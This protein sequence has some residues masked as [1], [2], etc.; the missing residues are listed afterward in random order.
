MGKTSSIKRLPPELRDAID[1]ALQRHVSYDEIVG[2]VNDLGGNVSRSAIGRYAKNYR[3]LVEQMRQMSGLLPMVSDVSAEQEVEESRLLS[4]L[5]RT[6]AT[7]TLVEAAAD[8]GAVDGK[9]FNYK[10]SG[11]EKAAKV[12]ASMFD[13]RKRLEDMKQRCAAAAE[14]AGQRAGASPETIA[15]IKAELLGL[16]I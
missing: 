4:Q 11:A 14:D 7:K 15:L 16:E 5:M 10:M 13:L 1:K 9:D 8:E 12:A 2:M 6:F 3:D